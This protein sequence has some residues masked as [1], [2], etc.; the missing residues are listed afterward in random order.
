VRA[1]AAAATA[2]GGGGGGAGGG[3]GSCDAFTETPFYVKF[4]RGSA[5]SVKRRTVVAAAACVLKTQYG[6]QS[7]PSYKLTFPYYFYYF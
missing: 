3:C 4:K 2:G 1:A 5:A 7:G 6:F